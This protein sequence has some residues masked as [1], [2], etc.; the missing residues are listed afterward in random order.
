MMGSALCVPLADREQDVALLGR[1]HEPAQARAQM[2]GATLECLDVLTL[3]E[4]AL[5]THA[6][7]GFAREE[8]QLL[9]HLIELGLHDA[10]LDMPFSELFPA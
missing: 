3:V 6:I 2:A 8:L 1:V 10:P 9:S 7:G 5:E 4:R